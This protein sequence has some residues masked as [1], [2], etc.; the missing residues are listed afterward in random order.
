MI[1]WPALA[2]TQG[3]P[4][5]LIP[6]LI[7]ID[8]FFSKATLKRWTAFLNAPD[9]PI[10]LESSPPAKT[11]EALRTNSRFQIDDA[12]FA[13]SLWTETALRELVAEDER[14]KSKFKGRKPAGLNSNIRIYRY[15]KGNQFKSPSRRC[16]SR[17]VVLTAP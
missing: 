3:K 12:N 11:G 17:N 9:T 2:P 14:F 6:G 4:V 16:Q 5:Q 15:D 7:I 13:D 8:D 10:K 1:D